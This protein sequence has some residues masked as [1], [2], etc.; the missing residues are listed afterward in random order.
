MAAKV[1]RKDR[2]GLTRIRAKKA[3]LTPG[4]KDR[5][6]AKKL[7]EIRLFDDLARK[8]AVELESI[9][10]TLKK[11]ID[12]VR[13]RFNRHSLVQRKARKA[14]AYNAFL[15]FKAKELEDDSGRRKMVN[16]ATSGRLK[17][18]YNALTAEEK[19]ELVKKLEEHRDDKEN[20]GHHLLKAQATDVNLVAHDV[21]LKLASAENRND[22][23]Y[24][25]IIANRNP[26]AYQNTTIMYSSGVEDF[27]REKYKC[28]PEDLAVNFEAWSVGHVSGAAA[29]DSQDPTVLT[30]EARRLVR[31]NWQ[32]VVG[33]SKPV[34]NNNKSLLA[35]H[36]AF[37][38]WPGGAPNFQKLKTPA[39]LRKLIAAVKSGEARW[40]KFEGDEL[41]RRLEALEEQIENGEVVIAARKPRSDLGGKHAPRAPLAA[42]NSD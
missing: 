39:A 19:H 23:H 1:H 31:E 15:H 37:E 35:H 16:M 29:V 26:R 2:R 7:E 17:D 18:E 5:I 21:K 38:G 9:S 25:C 30:Q 10:K 42:R 20:A 24:I 34:L 22:L 3:P 28:L 27:T 40:E 6:H 12:W 33:T 11:S 4:Q 8:E 41:D 13:V 14:S 32:S 36:V